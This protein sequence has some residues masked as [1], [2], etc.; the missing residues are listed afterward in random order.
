MPELTAPELAVPGVTAPGVTTPG[1]TTPGF[2]VSD[3]AWSHV[4]AEM[5]RAVELANGEPTVLP[6]ASAAASL[7][8]TTHL[9]LLPPAL[10]DRARRLQAEQQRTIT[11]LTARQ[12]EVARHLAALRTIPT[13]AAT[14]TPAYLD[15]ST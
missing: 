9:G 4:L 2:T 7:S 1:V 8:L 5:E 10:G 12:H 6:D 15:A 3:A 13:D 11:R 14:A